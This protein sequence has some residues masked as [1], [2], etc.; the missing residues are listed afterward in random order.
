[1]QI[2]VKVIPRARKEEIII[3]ADHLKVKVTAPPDKGAAN[4]AVI[5][6]LAKFFRIPQRN[7][8]LLQGES[9]RLKTFLI[10]IKEEEYYAITKTQ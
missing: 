6:L 9:S 8:I 3:E 1:M 10:A 2:Q 7:V 4:L 5:A